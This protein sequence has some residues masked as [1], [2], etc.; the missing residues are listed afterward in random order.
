LPQLTD[1]E[2]PGKLSCAAPSSTYGGMLKLLLL[3]KFETTTLLAPTVKYDVGIVIATVV[4]GA[5]C[6]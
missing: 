3:L 6:P 5:F 1:A 2:A 4:H